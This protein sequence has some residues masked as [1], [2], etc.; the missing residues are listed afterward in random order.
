M[1]MI[2]AELGLLQVQIKRS[3]GHTVELR[4]APLG[5]APEAFNAIDMHRAAGEL[6]GAVA[7]AKVFVKAYVHQAVVAAPAIGVDNAGN[8]GLAPDDGLQSAL[9]G[10]WHDL[11]VNTVST[12]E[13]PEHHG[14]AASATA[15]QA[16]HAPGPEVRLISF[17]LSNKRGARFAV[18]GH[19]SAHAQ[20]NR[21]DRA[22]R[23]T[24]KLGAICCG[25]I[26][27]EVAHDLAKLRFAE[28]GTLEVPVFLNHDRKL[29][30][31]TMRFAS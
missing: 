27:R 8:V 3:A 23:Q 4:Q 18:L 19:A 20:V 12:L 26:H 11:C 28:F 9:G 6:V 30:H 1:A 13:Q 31:L 14:F 21:V 17:Q 24:T 10:I 7:D 5:V 2:E 16:A 22:Q 29:A 15:T 25:Q